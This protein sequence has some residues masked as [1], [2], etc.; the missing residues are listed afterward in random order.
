MAL[1][2]GF[3]MA[4]Y[5]ILVKAS[6]GGLRR[7]SPVTLTFQTHFVGFLLAIPLVM[8][9][10]EAIT[11]NQWVLAFSMAGFG[12]AGQ[13]LIIKAYQ[14][15]DASLVAPFVY[16]EIVTST[17]FSWLFFHEMPDRITFIGVA[18]LIISSL[19]LIRR[20]RI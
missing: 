17:I 4:S 11:V 9:G 2:A 13:Y 7:V 18:I 12:L 1:G 6:V 14:L 20:R 19:F 5:A 8:I 3:A 10:W 15:S 16:L